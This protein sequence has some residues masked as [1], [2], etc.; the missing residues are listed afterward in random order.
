MSPSL[1]PALRAQ[2]DEVMS[3]HERRALTQAEIDVPPPPLG[4]GLVYG[5]DERPVRI[6]WRR[7]RRGLIVLVASA[8]VGFLIGVVLGAVWQAVAR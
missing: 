4:G 7:V 3:R 6:P 5:A 2:I 1:H 8:G